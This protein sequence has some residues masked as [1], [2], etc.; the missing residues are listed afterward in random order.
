MIYLTSSIANH[1]KLLEETGS[2]GFY[3]KIM[4]TKKMFFE[5]LIL[6]EAVLK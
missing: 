5:E 2:L 6:V 1:Q 3:T 4:A